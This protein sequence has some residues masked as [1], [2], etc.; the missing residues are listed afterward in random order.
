[1]GIGEAIAFK[2]A[3][4]RYNLVLVSRSE[5]KLAA[6]A[7]RLEAAS[8]S[9]KAI[10]RVADI[11]NSEAVD[12]AVAS[13]LKEVGT[14][15]V[16]INNAGLALGAPAAFP[17][18]SLSD[19]NTMISTNI[20]GLLYV[21]HA[22]LNHAMLNEKY[23]AGSG[24]VLNITSITGLEVPPFTGEAVYHAN[25]A[26]QE[27]FTNALRN[28]LSGTNVRVL[29]LR[30]GCVATNFHSLRVGHDKKQYDAFFD[31]FQ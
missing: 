19:I 29:A 7:K 27:A 1:M 31:G 22:V 24:T 15:D 23:G 28:E 10:Y 6:L 16:L 2:L 18:L 9:C 12:A 21:S 5:E 11:G 14:I 4:N 3:E 20:N 17:D 8:E 13:A 25:K 30:P 26:F